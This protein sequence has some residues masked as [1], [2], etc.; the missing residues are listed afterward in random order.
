VPQQQKIAAPESKIAVSI[1]ESGIA[2]VTI[3][4]PEKRNA[5][6]LAMWRELSSI[7]LEL[8]DQSAIR[9]VILSGTGGNFC[10]GADI[11]E[12]NDVRGGLESGRAYD[13]ITEATNIA[14]RDFPLPTIAAVSGYAVGGGCGLA[15]CCD[16]RVAD[17][18]TRM[19]IPAARLGIMYTPIECELLYRQVGL[20]SAKRILYSG[21]FYGVQDC[22]SMRLVDVIAI[23]A[24]EAALALA[25]EFVGNAPLSI[26]GSKFVLENIAAGTAAVRASDI[27][28]LIER[29]LQSYDYLEARKAFKEKR[30]PRFRGL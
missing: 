18:T 19:G 25:R 22:V 12:F 9:A 10:A 28:S 20:S 3:N 2:V 1:Q 6:S 15:L 29:T 24:Y 14:I 26:R 27:S 30:S 8:K 4:R 17:S 16:L 11:S 5:L 13:A 7:F 23:D 21:R